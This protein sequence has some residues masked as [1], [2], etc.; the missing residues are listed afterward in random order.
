VCVFVQPSDL[1]GAFD[2]YLERM[3][4]SAGTRSVYV[5]ALE[6]LAAVHANVPITALSAAAIDTY[7]ARWRAGFVARYGRMPSPATYRNRVNA[8]RALYSWLERFDLLRDERGTPIPNPMR[9]VVTPRVEQRRNDWLRPVEDAALMNCPATP[10]E[11]IIVALL[12]WTGMRVGEATSLLNGDVDL[13]AGCESIL[14]RRSKTEAGLR[15]IP[16]V[17]VLEVEVR[18]WLDR[19]PGASSPL[20]PFL[21]GR[22]GRPLP[23]SYVWRLVKRVA[24]RAGVCPTHCTCGDESGPRHSRECP[25]TVS[26]ENLSAV[27]PHTL[28]RTFGSDL[29]NR[30]LRL[31]VVSRLLGHASTT[32]TERCYAELL[33]STTR[34]EFLAVSAVAPQHWERADRLAGPSGAGAVMPELHRDSELVTKLRAS[35]DYLTSR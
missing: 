12:R 20:E 28:R 1:R 22:G 13:T 7:L 2:S 26:G 16:I 9:Q 21:A 10:T 34:R 32:V 35:L 33:D 11:R 25:R 17:P 27:T 5:Q 31:E 18:R 30:G 3:G 29:L 4:R 8:L 15:Q 6:H 23:A 19:G 24:F 14:V